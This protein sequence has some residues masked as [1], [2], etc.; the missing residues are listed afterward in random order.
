MVL[1][2]LYEVLVHVEHDTDRDDQYDGI[3]ICADEL[4]Y[5]IPVENADI[6][7]GFITFKTLRKRSLWHNHAQAVRIP[8]V[9]LRKVCCKCSSLCTRLMFF[10]FI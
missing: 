7:N 6:M 2:E 3:D 1:C 4:A 5:D 8:F 10:I 9:F